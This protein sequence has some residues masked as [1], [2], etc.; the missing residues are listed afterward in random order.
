MNLIKLVEKNGFEIVKTGLFPTFVRYYEEMAVA[1]FF[2]QTTG[3]FYVVQFSSIDELF[4]FKNNKFELSDIEKTG[5]W[6][7]ILRYRKRTSLLPIVNLN[8]ILTGPE[9]KVAFQALQRYI[10]AKLLG[11]DK[12]HGFDLGERVFVKS[13]GKSMPA[14]VIGMHERVICIKNESGSIQWIKTESN[15]I[16][17]IIK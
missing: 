2:E 6:G 12:K 7:D 10:D 8:H 11:W 15:A 5:F 4:E 9:F 13:E 17:K 16:Q 1:A 3:E 14:N